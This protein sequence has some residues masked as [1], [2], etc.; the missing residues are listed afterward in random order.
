MSTDIA[1]IQVGTEL[2]PL[3]L[4]PISRTTLAL[5]AGASGDH[6]PIHVDIDAAKAAGF[7]DVFAH[8]MLSMA[9]LGR[10]VTSWVPQS[11]LRSLST[12]F[13][14][15]TPVLAQPTCTGTVTSVD[16]VDGEKRATV[17]VKITLADGTV[18]LAGEAVVALP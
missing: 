13:T 17:D 12:R 9:Y 3:E 18:T 7:E 11:Q 16:E 2:P 1:E 14:A 8:G 4:A 5:F 10:L 6:N 15:I